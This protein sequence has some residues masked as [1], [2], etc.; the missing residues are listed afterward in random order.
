MLIRLPQQYSGQEIVKAFKAA[1]TFQE[2]PEIKWES[3]EF[4]DKFQYEPGSV[5]QTIRSIGVSVQSSFLGKKWILFGRKVWSLDRTPKFI[6]T[7]VVLSDRYDEVVVYVD[8]DPHMPAFEHIRPQFERT[9]GDFYDRLQV[10][11]F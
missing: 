2:S 8:A 5:K 9:L 7:P 11:H 3:H 6:L 4:V 1:S 10:K